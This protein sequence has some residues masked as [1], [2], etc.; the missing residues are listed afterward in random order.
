MQQRHNRTMKKRILFVI[1]HLELGGAQKQLLSIIKGLDS[2]RYSVYLC[3]GSCGY[4]KKEFSKVPFLHIKFIPQ[5]VR[6]ISPLSDLI[7]FLKLYFY[8]RKNKFDIVHTHSPKASILGRWAAHLAGVKNVVYTVH[9]W[10]FHRFMN[11]LLYCLYI[12][13]EKITVSITKKIIVVSYADLRKGIKKIISS[14]DKFAIIH[15]GVDINWVESVFLKRKSNFPPANLVTNISCLKP[16]KGLIYFLEA[17][18]LILDKRTDIKFSIVGDGPLRK[19]ISRQI[20][21][22]EL[23][24][25]VSLGGWIGDVSGL[26]SRTSV[27]V[28]TSLWEGL[29]LAVIEAVMSGVPAVVTD[30]EGVSDILDNYNNGIIFK[31]KDAKAI[32]DAVLTVLDGYGQW[33]EK[34]IAAREKLN[35]TYWSDERMVSQTERIYQELLTG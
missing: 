27:L 17:V 29:P 9:G 32:A 16:Q 30:T 2:Q 4:L 3:A 5:L 33:S 34:V 23:T 31:C 28:I 10:P 21:K 26:F 11:P 15:Y 20:S 6:N 1:T 19:S 7:T 18:R 24:E 13:L 8:I 22:R 25:H 35:L 12:F 14:P